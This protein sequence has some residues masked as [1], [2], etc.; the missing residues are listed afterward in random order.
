MSWD[1]YNNPDGTVT[2]CR[3]EWNEKWGNWGECTL[4]KKEYS[5]FKKNDKKTMD[6]IWRNLK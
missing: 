1:K 3:M 2:L 6:K 5:L 4:T